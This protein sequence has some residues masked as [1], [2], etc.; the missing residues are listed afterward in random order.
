MLVLVRSFCYTPGDSFNKDFLLLSSCQYKLL[1]FYTHNAS[2]CEDC[3]LTLPIVDLMR[4]FSYIPQASC[5]KEFL[6]L[7]F[8]VS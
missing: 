4:S 6:L 3:C 8:L 7:S 5:N 1:L 2:F